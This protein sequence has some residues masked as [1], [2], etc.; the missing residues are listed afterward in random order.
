MLLAGKIF[1]NSFGYPAYNLGKD[2]H[3]CFCEVMVSPLVA[4]QASI[5]VS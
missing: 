4:C 2:G 3:S 5:N 1:Y